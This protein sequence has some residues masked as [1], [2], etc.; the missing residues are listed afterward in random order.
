VAEY[1]PDLVILMYNA[2]SYVSPM[3]NFNLD[4]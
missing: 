2:D 4:K 3:F 1:Q